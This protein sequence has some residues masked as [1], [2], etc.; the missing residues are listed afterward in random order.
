[1]ACGDSGFYIRLSDGTLSSPHYHRRLE[2]TCNPVP[3]CLVRTT[4][5]VDSTEISSLLS[6][7]RI[8]S[9]A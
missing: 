9:S 2:V 1:V 6:V 5:S 4:G 7:I 3:F 8:T